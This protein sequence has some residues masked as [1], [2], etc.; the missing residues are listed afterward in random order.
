MKFRTGTLA[1]LIR[2][3]DGQHLCN[4]LDRRL[5]G[6]EGCAGLRVKVGEAAIVDPSAVAHRHERG[7]YTGLHGVQLFER[8]RSISFW[9]FLLSRTPV[10][11]HATSTGAYSCRDRAARISGGIVADFVRSVNP[12]YCSVPRRAREYE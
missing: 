3:D 12:Q 11:S 1:L 2:V 5:K 10:A 6:G 8:E 7:S 9:G 4:G